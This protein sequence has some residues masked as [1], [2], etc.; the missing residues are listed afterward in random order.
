MGCQVARNAWL[1]FAL[2]CGTM[3]LDACKV[4]SA[5]ITKK[6]KGKENDLT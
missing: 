6:E 5:S 1:I 4:K 3:I 2:E